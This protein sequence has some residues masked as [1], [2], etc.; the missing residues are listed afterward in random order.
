MKV[1][2][3]REASFS[4]FLWMIIIASSYMMH[5]RIQNAQ[6]SSN[7]EGIYILFSS[8]TVFDINY[9]LIA[10]VL[11]SHEEDNELI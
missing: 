4:T 6:L 11:N 7:A 10:L 2:W 8:K 5:L 9:G 3:F 1:Q